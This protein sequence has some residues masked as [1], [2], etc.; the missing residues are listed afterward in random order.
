[1][2]RNL[3]HL[4]LDTPV[5]FINASL[6]DLESSLGV[7]VTIHDLTGILCSWDGKPLLSRRNYHAHPYC[8]YRRNQFERQCVE[9]CSNQVNAYARKHSNAFSTHCFKGVREVVVPMYRQKQLAF[10]MF[11]GGFR[12]ERDDCPLSSQE[13]QSRY[14]QLTLFKSDKM[15]QATRLLKMVGLCLLQLVEQHSVQSIGTDPQQKQSLQ[16]QPVDR[17]DIDIRQFI[18]NHAHESTLRLEQLAQVLN[19]SESRVGHLV[20]EIFGQTFQKLVTQERI[21]RAKSLLITTDWPMDLVATATG[22][23][24]PYHF[25]RTF[26][27]QT[28]CTPGQYRKQHQR[29]S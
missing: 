7:Y 12:R 19:L 5:T 27:A 3:K 15:D 21:K 2:F 6:A 14:Q 22:F 23:G 18:F 13:A 20:K 9:H 1:M 24:N 25:N 16:T 4:N 17:R 11:A 28:Q 26:K 8:R 29:T 10:V